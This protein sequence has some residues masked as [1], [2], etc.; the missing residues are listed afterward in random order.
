MKIIRYAAVGGTAAAVDF[1]IFASFAKFF[2][3]K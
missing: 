2:T 3:A 1:V